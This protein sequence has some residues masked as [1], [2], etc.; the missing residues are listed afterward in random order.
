MSRRT[1]TYSSTPDTSEVSDNAAR[2]RWPQAQKSRVS[3]LRQKLVHRK[4]EAADR[5]QVWHPSPQDVHDDHHPPRSHGPHI[6][7]VP[8]EQRHFTQRLPPQKRSQCDRPPTFATSGPL[9]D[10]EYGLGLSDMQPYAAALET[11]GRGM[12]GAWVD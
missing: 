5:L 4:L 8:K 7:L 3:S 6:V 1:I 11:E 2:R 9:D 10:D 12:V